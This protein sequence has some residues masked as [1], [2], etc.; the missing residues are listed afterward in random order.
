M[1]FHV[2]LKLIEQ[3]QVDIKEE[4]IEI[5][6]YCTN[7]GGTSADLSPGEIYSLESLLYGLMLPS[8]NDAALTLALWGGKFQ[9]ANPE[10]P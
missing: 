10:D 5:Q 4:K 6:F 3:F 2:V 8:G 9:S 1:T 7:I